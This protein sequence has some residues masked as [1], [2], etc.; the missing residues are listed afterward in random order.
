M[1]PANDF[2]YAILDLDKYPDAIIYYATRN[3]AI[4]EID[5]VIEID[6][7]FKALSLQGVFIHE[8]R[9]EEIKTFRLRAYGDSIL[10]F[11][12]VMGKTPITEES[13]MLSMHPS[14]IP[15]PLSLSEDNSY[16]TVHDGMHRTR[17][18]IR[19]KPDPVNVWSEEQPPA[20]P[21]LETEFLPDGELSV[22][23]MSHDQF[24]PGKLDSLPLAYLKKEDRVIAS[25]LS[26]KAGSNECFS[27]T[28]ER[29]AKIDLSGRTVVLENT[30]GLGNNGRKTYKNVPFYLSSAGYGLFMHSSKCGR[31]S[32]SDVSNRSVQ[33][34]F[35]D[36]RMDAFIIGGGSPEPIL[37]QYRQLTGFSPEMPLWSY[38][39]WMSRMTYYSAQEVEDIVARLIKEDYPLDVIHL[40]TGYFPENWVCEWRFSDKRFPHPEDFLS[41]LRDKGIRIT[42]WQTP[43]IGKNNPLYNEAIAKGIL[44][45]AGKVAVTGAVS[46]FSGQDWGGQIDFSN[47]AAVKWYKD[48]LRGLLDMGVAAI[49]TDFGEKI[50]MDSAYESMSPNELH[51]I[52][53]LLYQKAAFEVSAESPKKAMIWA[54][55]GWAGSQR[56]PL[57]WGG[58]TSSTWDGMAAVLRGGLHLGLSGFSYWSHDIPGFHGLPEFMNTLPSEN[59]YLRWTQFGILSSHTRYH[60]ASAREPWEYPGVS[61]IV[62]MWWKLRYALIP[63]LRQEGRNCSVTGLPMIAALSFHHSRNPVVWHIDDQYYL[64]RNLLVAPIM[65]DKGVRDVYLPSGEWIDFFTG[66]RIQGNQWLEARLWPKATL[67]LFVRYGALLPFYLEPVNNTDEM[68]DNGIKEIRFDKD[69]RG[70]PES[71]LGTVTGFTRKDLEI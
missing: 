26:L 58:D 14:L 70:V 7:P 41:R 45:P 2:A 32:F 19:K 15:E 55:A 22:P 68:T 29:F 37:R 35:D 20:W 49:K 24:F 53:G 30:D 47:P 52:Y 6:I 57:H 64:G 5:G 62:R 9:P 54:R 25:F 36:D 21:M 56:Y 34:R 4:R 66:E 11:S 13:V 38:G 48:K 61:D 10:R 46:D 40:D 43:N 8:D 60:G 51:N 1:K 16:W 17:M 67:P 50:Q 63:Y 3:I 39:I 69:Y 28:G 44:P 59:L 71:R 31:I 12:G 65:N 18:K 33:N 27:G 42:L 23:L